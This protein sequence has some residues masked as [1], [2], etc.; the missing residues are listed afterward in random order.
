MSVCDRIHQAQRPFSSSGLR[1]SR[2]GELGCAVGA[3]LSSNGRGS[4]VCGYGKTESY[5]R[6][7]L[8]T[9]V[10]MATALTS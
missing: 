6:V 10:P 5:V 9:T 1:W 2:K 3:I 8:M 4:Q 7:K